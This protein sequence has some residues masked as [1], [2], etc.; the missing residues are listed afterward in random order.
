MDPGLDSGGPTGDYCRVL[1]TM[2]ENG[3]NNVT[4][5]NYSTTSRWIASGSGGG[6]STSGSG[7]ESDDTSYGYSFNGNGNLE[8]ASG[9]YDDPAT[10]GCFLFRSTASENGNG[11]SSSHQSVAW[12]LSSTANTWSSSIANQSS[13]GNSQYGYTY[14]ACEISTDASI[15][16]YGEIDHAT[17]SDQQQI[18]GWFGSSGVGSSAASWSGSAGNG[19]AASNS[20]AYQHFYNPMSG[21]DQYLK[22]GSIDTWSMPSSGGPNTVS[23]CCA[24][25]WYASTAPTAGFYSGWT[26]RFYGEHER[27]PFYHGIGIGTPPLNNG[28]APFNLSMMGSSLNTGTSTQLSF[29]QLGFGMQATGQFKLASTSSCTFDAAGRLA[30]IT[31]ANSAVTQ[32]THDA[33]GNLSSLTDPDGNTTHWFYNPQNQLTQENQCP[34][35]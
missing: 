9:N 1:G 5:G 20:W 29:G 34:G 12:S 18:N 6:S 35:Q 14:H 17:W 27:C 30:S 31:D 10:C 25:A 33:A 11:S 16:A 3:S 7:S 28:S 2:Q 24:D 4:S 26:S 15:N 13:S 22:A 21:S 8:V 23:G 19:L 32:F